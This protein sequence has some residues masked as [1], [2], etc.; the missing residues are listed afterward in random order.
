MVHAP[1]PVLREPIWSPVETLLGPDVG[2]PGQGRSAPDLRSWHEVPPLTDRSDPEVVDLWSVTLGRRVDGRSTLQAE[3]VKPSC[4][5][6][7]NLHIV[8]HLTREQREGTLPRGSHGAE[9]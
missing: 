7:S 3:A 4:S 5:T 2:G 8:L 1:V 6:R 9:G